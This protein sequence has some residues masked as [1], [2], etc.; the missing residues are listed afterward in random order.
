M[1]KLMF[2]LL[3][4]TWLSGCA[5]V[6]HEQGFLQD[7]LI[8]AHK[9]DGATTMLDPSTLA[10]QEVLQRTSRI[11]DS[12]VFVS[13]SRRA[14]VSLLVDPET[15]QRSDYIEVQPKQ[16][17]DVPDQESEYDRILFVLSGQYE[18]MFFLH[19]TTQYWGA[20]EPLNKTSMISL[21]EFLPSD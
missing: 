14:A 9:A 7:A 12:S 2:L 4:V 21:R 13:P 15:F 5:N 6:T 10:Y 1:R 3:W 18:G 8:V 17:F 20:W 19:A 16:P 11:L